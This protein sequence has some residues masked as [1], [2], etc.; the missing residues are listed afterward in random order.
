MFNT[1]DLLLKNIYIQPEKS[2]QG[3]ESLGRHP[4]GCLE[5]SWRSAYFDNCR[6]VERICASAFRFVSRL[7]FRYP[8]KWKF[9]IEDLY[10]PIPTVCNVSE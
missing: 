1:V 2:Q 8:D 7:N 10:K 3:L 4:K 5:F 9:E 6:G